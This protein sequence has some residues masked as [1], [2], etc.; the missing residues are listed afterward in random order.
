MSDVNEKL[1]KLDE[2]LDRI[3]LTLVKNTQILDE[4]QRRSTA[5][6]A[7]VAQLEQTLKEE[8]TPVKNHVDTM[9]LGFKIIVWIAGASTGVAAFV[10]T[11]KEL[12]II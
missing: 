12:N 3:E 9:K 8:L 10:L 5:N 1:D 4:H 6:E 2:R 11:L 7:H